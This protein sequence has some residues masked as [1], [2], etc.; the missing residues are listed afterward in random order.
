M[1]PVT[2]VVSALVAGAAAGTTATVSTAISDAYQALKRLVAG[3]LS[4][5]GRDPQ[6]IDEAP[7]SETAQARLAEELH[8]VGVD[9]TVRQMAQELME[10]LESRERG[11][12]VVDASSAKGVIIGDHSVQHNTFN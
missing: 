5:A 1:D 3:R 11:K 4:G 8:A 10:L 12:F 7:G 6:V 9:D 2:L